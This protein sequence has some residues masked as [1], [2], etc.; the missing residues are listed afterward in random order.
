MH[1]LGRT[2]GQAAP[3][4]A[5]F[6]LDGPLGAGKTTFAQGV[7]AGC[8][9]TEPITSPTYNLILHYSG[10]RSFTHADFYRLEDE[11]GLETLDLDEIL[12][13]DGVACVEWP[14]LITD[15]VAPPRALV[16]IE[17]DPSRPGARSVSIRT[18]GPGWR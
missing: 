15:R 5:V 13:G 3:P 9:V 17:P 11:A 2:L 18:E 10:E 4:G 16:R 7:G 14:V 6:L 1:E 8:G 12:S